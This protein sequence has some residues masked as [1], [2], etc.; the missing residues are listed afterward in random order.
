MFAYVVIMQVIVEGNIHTLLECFY[1]LKN[2][3]I[4]K[5]DD[6]VDV[7][8][9]ESYDRYFMEMYIPNNIVALFIGKNG[10]AIENIRQMAYAK[11]TIEQK[12]TGYEEMTSVEFQGDH[13]GIP[14]AVNLVFNRILTLN[15]RLSWI[16]PS[17]HRM[18]NLTDTIGN[19][20]HF[21]RS[22]DYSMALMNALNPNVTVFSYLN[23]THE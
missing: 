4:R 22:D 11:I 1:V 14:Q 3:I 13:L 10:V 5:I 21:S 17:P 6:L 2:D 8:E 18:S 20:L 9:G 19:I 15:P 7:V 16:Y 12:N 23:D